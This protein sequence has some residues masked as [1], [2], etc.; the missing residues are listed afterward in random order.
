MYYKFPFIEDFRGKLT[1]FKGGFTQI[2]VPI[3]A[4]G[5]THCY[6]ELDEDEFAGFL[7]HFGS[8]AGEIVDENSYELPNSVMSFSS[9]NGQ[10]GWK[11][12]IVKPNR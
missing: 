5:E 10:R 7:D 1:S 8:D 4:S 3:P 9:N 2:F 11:F 6:V 12:D